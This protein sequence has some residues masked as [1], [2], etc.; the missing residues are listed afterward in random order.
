MILPLKPLSVNQA[1]QGKRFKTPEYKAYERAA[2]LLLPAIKIPIGKLRIE[3]DFY[4]SN[5]ASD[6]DNP[7]KPTLDILQKRYG[8]NDK[9]IYEL[10]TRKH[11]VKKGEEKTEIKITNL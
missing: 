10:I 11:I 1:W 8:F 6:L 9:D 2:L 5:Q 7:Q 3:L 4:F